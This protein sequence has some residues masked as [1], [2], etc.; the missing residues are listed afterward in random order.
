MVVT[1][2]EGK[3]GGGERAGGRGCVCLSSLSLCVLV[4]LCVCVGEGSRVWF[5]LSLLAAFVVLVSAGGF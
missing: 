5:V 3:E 2:E 4:L 1:G